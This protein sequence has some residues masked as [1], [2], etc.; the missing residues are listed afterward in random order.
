MTLPRERGL[1]IGVEETKKEDGVQQEL[2]PVWP[3]G[4]FVSVGLLALFPLTSLVFFLFLRLGA[5]LLD[6]ALWDIS[7]GD[8]GCRV[9]GVW[10]AMRSSH[11]KR[12]R[13]LLYKGF[14]KVSIAAQRYAFLR[15]PG[16][17][18]L[19]HGEVTEPA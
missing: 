12:L 19:R 14:V 17:P 7:A 9:R 15:E 11:A 2:H 4:C 1:G 6:A 10:E 5:C 13:S 3:F 18:H 8:L 16:Q